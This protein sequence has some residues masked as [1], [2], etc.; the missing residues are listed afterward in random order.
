MAERLALFHPQG[1]RGENGLGVADAEG[2]EQ[3]EPFSTVKSEACEKGISASIFKDGVSGASPSSSRMTAS[4]RSRSSS[5]RPGAIPEP[6]G[7][8]VPAK[9]EQHVGAAREARVEVEFR[10]GAA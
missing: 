8:P 7:L 9:A 5:R 2:L 3:F 1:Q 4:K 10:N 6:C